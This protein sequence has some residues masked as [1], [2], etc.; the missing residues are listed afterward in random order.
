[1][2]RNQLDV[3][4]SRLWG[5]ITLTC[6]RARLLPLAAWAHGVCGSHSLRPGPLMKD[7]VRWSVV[8]LPNSTRRRRA[9][10]NPNAASD[11]T[12]YV[13]DQTLEVRQGWVEGEQRGDTA[14][15]TMALR[16]AR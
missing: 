8:T 13:D 1:M 10:S 7:V 5:L 4:G 9:I 15:S 2:R 12:A 3:K 16:P 6:R 11:T 14:R